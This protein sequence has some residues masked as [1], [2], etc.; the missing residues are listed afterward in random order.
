VRDP[1]PGPELKP[2]SGCILI[3][4]GNVGGV[5]S[6]EFIGCSD[7]EI[8]IPKSGITCLVN[9]SFHASEKRLVLPHFGWHKAEEDGET[10]GNRSRRPSASTAVVVVAVAVSAAN[11]ADIAHCVHRKTVQLS[12]SHLFGGF[13]GGKSTGSIAINA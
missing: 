4:A 5:L 2:R 10:S 11:S 8:I 6:F 9:D 1:V 12:H 7:E 13:H 3:W